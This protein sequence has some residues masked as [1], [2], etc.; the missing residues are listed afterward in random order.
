MANVHV[1]YVGWK[2]KVEGEEAFRTHVNR[3]EAVAHGRETARETGGELLIH[4]R[5]GQIKRKHSYG[6]GPADVPG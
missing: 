1:T 2:V 6:N 3:S 5:H 4:G